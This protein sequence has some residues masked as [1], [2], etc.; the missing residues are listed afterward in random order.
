MLANM[1]HPTMTPAATPTGKAT[2]VSTPLPTTGA[3][4]GLLAALGLGTVGVGVLLALAAGK[5]IR[6]RR[7]ADR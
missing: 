3:R 7:G 5:G 6:R 2:S 1:A 4:S